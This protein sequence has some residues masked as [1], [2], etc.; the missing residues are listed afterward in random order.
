M[1]AATIDGPRERRSDRWTAHVHD[2]LVV[3]IVV[4][5]R[6]RERCVGESGVRHSNLVAAS[7]DATRTLRR[8]RYGAGA[9]RAT[10]PRALSRQRK[11]DHVED[12][13]LRRRHHVVWQILESNARDPFPEL[14]GKR[15]DY[16][17][18]A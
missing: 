14:T 12:A 16:S 2:R 4:L 9:N 18:G 15:H 7:Q 1:H 3:R 5:E 10:E 17:P 8:D 6:L 11:P 13:H